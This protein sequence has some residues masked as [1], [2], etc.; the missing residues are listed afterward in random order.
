LCVMENRNLFP[1]HPPPFLSL[2]LYYYVLTLQVFD[3]LVG[4]VIEL[5]PGS[6][7][8]ADGLYI[9]GEN[10]TSDESAMTGESDSVR[11]DEDDPF[12][13]SGCTVRM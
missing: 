8:P 9:G 12:M 1:Y 5:E 4:D 10:V 6:P 7:I 3:V 13:L 11:K 2:F